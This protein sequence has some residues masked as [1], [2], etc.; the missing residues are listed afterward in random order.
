MTDFTPTPGTG[1]P[2]FEP[3]LD[4]TLSGIAEDPTAAE[5][6][7][8]PIIWPFI[9]ACIVAFAMSIAIGGLL[10]GVSGGLGDFKIMQYIAGAMA[11]QMVVPMMAIPAWVLG[12]L[13]A[14]VG[15]PR[16]Y[17]DIGIGGLLGSIMLLPLLHGAHF[18][19]QHAAFILGGLTGGFAF[20]R[21]QGYPGKS[22]RAA[23][24]ADAAGRVLR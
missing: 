6:P 23:K 7:S 15:V 9:K 24:V 18:T 12:R 8:V 11:A 20:W 17:A 4:P 14:L 2:S 10:S 16:G 1:Q 3:R 5:P 21:A 22:A 13:S 19:T